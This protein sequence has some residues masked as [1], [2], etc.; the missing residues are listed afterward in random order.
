M[1]DCTQFREWA[2]ASLYLFLLLLGRLAQKP[3]IVSSK[4]VYGE[5]ALGAC[6]V[7]GRAKNQQG[8]AQAS[9]GREGTGQTSRTQ[10]KCS[11]RKWRWRQHKLSTSR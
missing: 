5:R 9:D 11:K 6:H 4:P 1:L 8:I 10:Q 3:S 2:Q 7:H